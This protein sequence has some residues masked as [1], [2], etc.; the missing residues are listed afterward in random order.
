MNLQKVRL[1]SGLWV[2]GFCLES[3]HV[4]GLIY[5]VLN[6]EVHELLKSLIYF[7]QIDRKIKS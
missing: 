6:L 7:K 3:W 4:R 5:E 1:R 2:F